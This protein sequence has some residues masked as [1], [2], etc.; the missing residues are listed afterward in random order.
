[1]KKIKPIRDRDIYSKKIFQQI[2]Y[3]LYQL[4]YK[5]LFEILELKEPKL[6]AKD[7]VEDLVKAFERGKLTWEDGYVYGKFNAS[8]SKAL[9]ALG[10]EYNKT[11]KAY[12]LEKS[13]LP[14]NIRTAMA[15]AKLR[16]EEAAEKLRKKIEEF[17][18]LSF[19]EQ[20]V[21]VL[22]ENIVADLKVQFKKVTPTELEIALGFSEQSEAKI[23]EDYVT[24]L[25][26][27][28]QKWKESA[29]ERLRMEVVGATAEGMRHEELAKVIQREYKISERKAKFISRQETSLMVSKFRQARY[30]EAGVNQYEWST[31]E[32]HRVRHDHRELNGKIFSWDEPPIVDR[33]T[34]RRANP[35]E[36]FMCRCVALPIIE[37]E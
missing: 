16:Q 9:R 32:D 23:M 1:M 3:E 18:A 35:G 15:T 36:D 8:L 28:I 34:G 11:R 25:K 27:N 30:E 22:A 26:L 29:T 7:K 10:G 31:S 13:M 4:L 21:Y 6:N 24:N 17:E 19:P 20:A 12:K 33:A 14:T 2:N 37:G 5:P